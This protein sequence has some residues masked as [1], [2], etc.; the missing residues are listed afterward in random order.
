[1]QLSKSRFTTGL[2][3]HRRLWWTV[4]E[5]DAP[6]LQVDA[7]LQVVFDH[8]SD[9]GEV[10]RGYIPGGVLIDLPYYEVKRRL[11][12]TRKALE[13]GAKVLYE[14]SFQADD[15]FVAVD[16]LHRSRRGWT[17]TEVKST[18]SVKA[19]HIP[20]A[21]IQTHVVRKAGLDVTR[22]EVMHLNTQ[23]RHPHLENLFTR[24]DVTE[25][26]EANLPRIPREVRRQDRPR[27]DGPKVAVLRR[28]QPRR[29]AKVMRVS[30][31]ECRNEQRG[32]ERDE[33]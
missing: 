26:V 20:D 31:A 32:I 2:Q 30:F 24:A 19:A 29:C 33:H 11:A 12:E 13:R 22:T 17:V 21:A 1:M 9:A 3:C 23:C 27:R 7:A 18:A 6:E 15:V 14:A 16:I 4:H 28:C 8:G 25:Q 5:R 10:A